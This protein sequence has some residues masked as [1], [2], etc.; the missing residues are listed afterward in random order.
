[1]PGEQNFLAQRYL[2][3]W[4]RRGI[5]DH[6]TNQKLFG[7]TGHHWLITSHLELFTNFD[8]F[9]IY[10]TGTILRSTPLHYREL[11][12]LHRAG[13]KVVLL[14]YGGDVQVM[15]RFRGTFASRP[16]LRWLP[17]GLWGAAIATSLAMIF[18]AGALS[19]TVWRK[20]GIVMAI[21]VPANK[22]VA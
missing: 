1:M 15:T 9:T 14:A 18:E 6:K 20:L 7:I 17:F 10:A 3:F 13:K 4:T 12:L 5:H 19:F 2:H 16:R 11:Q 22:E 8:V 21:F